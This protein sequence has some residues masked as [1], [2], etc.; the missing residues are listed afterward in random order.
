MT[1]QTSIEAYHK[2]KEEGLLSKRRLE[3]YE[4]LYWFGPLSANEVFFKMSKGNMGPVNAASNSA[5][6]FSELRDRGVIRESGTKICS[7]TKM[8]VIQWDVTSK[9][10]I[11]IKNNIKHKCKHCNGTG[12]SKE[13]ED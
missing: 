1:R 5:A 11:K 13:N 4:I 7:I 8:N 6:R 10:P 2:I 12:F 3:V 9:L